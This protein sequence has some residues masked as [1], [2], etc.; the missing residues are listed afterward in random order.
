MCA[1]KLNRRDYSPRHRSKPPSTLDSLHPNG[2]RCV[3]A[4]LLR[5]DGE[6]F[7]L[8]VALVASQQ[9]MQAWPKQH[10]PR[11]KDEHA[12]YKSSFRADQHWPES[13]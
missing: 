1:A 4:G 7:M 11:V 8:V 13:N 6:Q 2:A 10:H 12:G 3:T 5:A 9:M